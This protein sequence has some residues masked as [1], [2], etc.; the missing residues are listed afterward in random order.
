MTSRE[1]CPWTAEPCRIAGT[2]FVNEGDSR[3][4][5][6]FGKKSH[7]MYKKKKSLYQCMEVDESM[8]VAV[9][10]W[11]RHGWQEHGKDIART[12][13]EHGKNMA[14]TWQEHGKDMARAW[15]RHGK[16]MAKH[17]NNMAKSWQEHGKAMEKTWQKHGEDVARA[18]Q[19]HAKSIVNTWQ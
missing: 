13:Q 14:Q 6:K 15:Q 18:W 7:P 10:A 19:S 4:S 3:H 12:W 17:C 2:F 16:S 11:Q 1:T 5:E 8:V 9:P